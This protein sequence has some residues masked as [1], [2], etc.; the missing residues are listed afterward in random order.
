MPFET[1]DDGL[2]AEMAM[3]SA[4]ASGDT[5]RAAFF[6]SVAAPC[7]VLPDRYARSETYPQAAR[8]CAAA[9]WPVSTRKTG[10]GITPQGPGVLN[11]A[12]AFTVAPPKGRDIRGSYAEI[13]DPLTEAFQTLGIA[14]TAQPVEG[15]FCD[16]DYNLAVAGRKIVGTAQRWRGNT[17][18][19]HALILTDIDLA[20]AVT[21]VQQLAT[22]LGHDTRFALDVHSRLADL[23]THPATLTEDLNAALHKAL[24]TRAYADWTPASA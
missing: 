18:L 17:C 20:P 2:A 4:V 12:L 16:G 5:R 24:T 6:W 23:A 10:G 1:A 21:A 7:L 19:A 15:S 3:L 11:V 13:T 14:S 8:T 22:A 9:G